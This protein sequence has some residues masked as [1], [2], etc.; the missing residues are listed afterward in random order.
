M[1]LARLFVERVIVVDD[2]STD[3]TSQV[4]RLAGAEVVTL[5]ENSGKAHALLLGLKKARELGCKAVVML[6]ADGQ[7][8]TKDIPRIAAAALSGD[9]DLVIGSR[10]LENNGNG[11]IPLYRQ[12]D[13]N[14]RSLHQHRFP[15]ERNR[16]PMPTRD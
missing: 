6:D 2:G 12:L 5:K 3:K 15:A 11:N 13:K 4:A 10:F 14:P 7:H 9:A 1:I 8:F 16:F